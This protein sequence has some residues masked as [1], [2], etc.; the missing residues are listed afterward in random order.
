MKQKSHF[1][2]YFMYSAATG[3]VSQMRILPI[4]N[5]RS[6]SSSFGGSVWNVMIRCHIDISKTSDKGLD[7]SGQVM[8]PL[9]A[10]TTG[11]FA[12]ASGDGAGLD[13]EAPANP[14]K[15]LPSPNAL[16]ENRQEIII[17]FRTAKQFL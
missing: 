9:R 3:A 4:P 5:R 14:L 15:K 16:K 1:L 12:F 8:P 7:R 2:P 11:S 17:S 6:E 10:A 13:G